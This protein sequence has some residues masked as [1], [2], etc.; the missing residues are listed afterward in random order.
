MSG[1]YVCSIAEIG[2]GGRG[3]AITNHEY[4]I[5]I[6][7]NHEPIGNFSSHA[8]RYGSAREGVLPTRLTYVV[9]DVLFLCFFSSRVIDTI[10]SVVTTDLAD[11]R[12]CWTVVVNCNLSCSLLM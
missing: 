2:R 6:P 11:R 9:S 7:S 3:E 4:F 10:V 1:L 8:F 12:I 5:F